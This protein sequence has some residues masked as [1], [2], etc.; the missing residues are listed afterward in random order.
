MKRAGPGK[1]AGWAEAPPRLLYK[2]GPRGLLGAS[3]DG[4]RARECAG[5]RLGI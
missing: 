5:L 3:T 4:A 1:G 2:L